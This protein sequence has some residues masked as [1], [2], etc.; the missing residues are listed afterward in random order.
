MT[1]ATGA[2]VPSGQLDKEMAFVGQVSYLIQAFSVYPLGLGAKK[3]LPWNIIFT[4]SG[5]LLKSH[6]VLSHQNSVRTEGPL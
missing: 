6:L 3:G 5:C 1:R 2:G 4:I